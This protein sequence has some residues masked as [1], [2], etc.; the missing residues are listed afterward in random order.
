[1]IGNQ[2][3]NELRGMRGDDVLYSGGGR[4]D[5]LFGGKGKEQFWIDVPLGFR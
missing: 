4:G 2:A 3:A 1:M 5:R